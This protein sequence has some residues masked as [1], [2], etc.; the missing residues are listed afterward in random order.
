MLNLELR[1]RLDVSSDLERRDLESLLIPEGTLDLGFVH[2]SAVEIGTNLSSSSR[3]PVPDGVAVVA[4]AIGE[5]HWAE[6]LA[7][8]RGNRLDIIESLSTTVSLSLPLHEIVGARS[9]DGATDEIKSNQDTSSSALE[10]CSLSNDDTSSPLRCGK[11]IRRAAPRSENRMEQAPFAL[12]VVETVGLCHYLGFASAERRDSWAAALALARAYAAIDES[13]INTTSRDPRD[14]FVLRPVAYHGDRLVLNGRRL[15]LD[16]DRPDPRTPPWELALQLLRRVFTLTPDADDFDMASIFDQ[17]SALRHLP[18]SA[19]ENQ[20]PKEAMVF[21]LN[22]HHALLQHALLLLGAPKK[23]AEIHA[24]ASTISYDMLGDIFSLHEIA[25][26]VLRGS[27]YHQE[28]NAIHHAENQ[29]TDDFGNTSENAPKVKSEVAA[30]QVRTKLG[31]LA[32]TGRRNIKDGKER[33][34]NLYRAAKAKQAGRPLSPP[35]SKAEEF[36][37]TDYQAESP[38]E[39]MSQISESVDD[40]HDREPLMISKP[41]PP[42]PPL[43]KDQEHLYQHNKHQLAPPRP[44]RKTRKDPKKEKNYCST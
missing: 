42:P 3:P 2:G 40:T 26:C 35:S 9:I 38:A 6:Q 1:R 18:L 4:R 25:T 37:E 31:L 29:Q 16:A 10:D 8:L 28:Y 23:P 15:Q 34:T 43:P 39:T 12:L 24:F 22:I 32:S 44:R 5:A 33:L 13:A 41:P 19:L 30:E 20:T 27:F 36:V 21:F 17:A 14:N 7:V 11:F